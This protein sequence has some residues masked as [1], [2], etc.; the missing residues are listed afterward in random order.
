MSV[1]ELLAMK[2]DEQRWL[3]EDF[4]PLDGVAIISGR[5]KVG[6][7]VLCRNLAVAVARG[8][9]FFGHTTTAGPVLF[10]SLEDRPR[11]V[12]DHFRR[13]KVES[14]T[15]LHFH[16]GRAPREAVAQIRTL[17]EQHH[18][19]LIVIDTLFKVARVKD[20]SAYNEVQDVL[21]DLL[22]LARELPCFVV[23]VHHSPKGSDDRDPIDAPLGSTAI[24]GMADVLLHLTRSRDGRRLLSANY[25]AGAGKDLA[26]TVV[27]LDEST[28][29]VELGALKTVADEQ[30]IGDA[31][32]K[33]LVDQT[34]PVN[35]SAISEHVS[36]RKQLRLKSLNR[37]VDCRRVIRTGPGTR[38]KPF[39]YALNR[40]DPDDPVRKM[41]AEA[42]Q[43]AGSQAKP[44]TLDIP[45]MITKQMEADLR[46]KGDS[47]PQIDNRKPEQARETLARQA[48]A[49]RAPVD[50][51]GRIRKPGHS[52][53]GKRIPIFQKPDDV[54]G[55]VAQ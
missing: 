33:F 36:G 7:G 14:G 38:G 37:L 16:F 15:P 25:R 4:L 17:A 18:P 42:R 35:E 6:K 27:T 45:V 30:A 41:I 28:G 39:L 10:F 50:G 43:Q 13:L 21:E 5:P 24:A 55:G 23:L 9:P 40:I 11:D 1:D 8:L 49:K 34:E 31:I 29:V 22:D 3:V 2:F 53:T 19:V 51:H 20:S 48:K 52:I 44:K 26:E 12:Q 54:N 32:L 47:Q 46:S